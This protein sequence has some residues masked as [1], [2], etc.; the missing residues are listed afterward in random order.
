MLYQPSVA[1]R[2]RRRVHLGHATYISLSPSLSL[3]RDRCCISPQW[4][5]V[6]TNG[7]LALAWRS[8]AAWQKVAS[9]QVGQIR[10]DQISKKSFFF[11]S[12][13]RNGQIIGAKNQKPA[14]SE[15]GFPKPIT[16]REI[17]AA[18]FGRRFWKAG[19]QALPKF[20]K[21]DHWS[22]LSTGQIWPLSENR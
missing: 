19:V 14:K 22:N 10:L 4:P 8:R 21:F 7:P 3:S 11:G 6:P 13:P 18:T 1:P 5:Y 20:L 17:I 12:D 16:F 9:G 2:G 15:V